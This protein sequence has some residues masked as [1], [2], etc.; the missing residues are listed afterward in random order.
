M[1]YEKQK[2][3][4]CINRAKEWL[5]N[6]GIQ[7]TNT[8]SPTYGSF[9]AWYD[10]EGKDYSFAYSEITGYAITTLLF[11]NKINPDKLLVERAKL[12]SD[13][14][15]GCAYDNINGGFRC[16]YY[17]NNNAFFP[18]LCSFDNGIC[19]NGLVNLYRYT[20]NEKYLTVSKNVADWLINFM[21]KGDG[22][23]YAKY[24]TQEK[25]FIDNQERWSMQSGSYHVK[26]AIGLLN[27][28]N[29][30]GD[31]T[32]EEEVKRLCEYALKFQ[33]KDG[34][35]ITNQRL[36]DTYMHPHC[37][38]VEG[39]F[40]AGLALNKKAYVEKAIQ[41]TKWTLKAYLSNGGV[42][43][44]YD[45]N[46]FSLD[47]STDSLSQSIRLWLLLSEF[48]GVS[49]PDI[50]LVKAI[51]RLCD[52]QCESEDPQASGGFFYGCTG[53][54]KVP[55]VNVGST[56]FAL[57]TLEFCRQKLEGNINFDQ[58]LLV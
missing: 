44:V 31:P 14:L 55:H 40:C 33:T 49:C 36:G 24:H 38:S 51:D 9:R 35:F 11:L 30:I 4:F 19:L 10:M 52:F 56:M 58:R 25:R 50:D 29:A 15:I 20:S 43:C 7:D 42:S 32:Y 13:W 37:Y 26:I 34:R 48:G 46:A 47:E 57:Q 45:G 17:P 16:R 41:G 3:V 22:S 27:L 6:S 18:W 53:G 5:L 23:L 54:H 2:L 21:G 8:G 1:S 39:L 12:A 28:S